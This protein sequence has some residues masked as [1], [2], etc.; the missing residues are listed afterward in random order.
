M[1]KI[2]REHESCSNNFLPYQDL[3]KLLL[4]QCNHWRAFL[5][6]ITNLCSW[7]FRLWHYIFVCRLLCSVSPTGRLQAQL[8]NVPGSKGKEDKQFLEVKM[9]R[10]LL[11]KMII[12]K[13]RNLFIYLNKFNY[14][15][16]HIS[17][18]CTVLTKLKL[19]ST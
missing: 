8:R 10:T 7:Y 17:N 11:N 13:G 6:S 5:K 2:L 18:L 19:M 16:C 14:L 3:T 4:L 12:K 1:S 15:V 9:S